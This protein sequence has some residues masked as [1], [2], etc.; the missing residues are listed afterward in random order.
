MEDD[1][2][3]ITDDNAAEV[4]EKLFGESN[5]GRP[6]IALQLFMYDLFAHAD[7]SLKDRPIV[8]SIYSTGRLYTG[9]LPDMPESP[10]FTS[11]VKERLK[12]MLDEMVNLEVPFK[13]TTESKTCEWCDFKAICGR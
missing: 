8:N 3:L 9:P 10:A 4:V 12:L 13:L 11:L 6:K 5:K 2:I 7:P 1:D